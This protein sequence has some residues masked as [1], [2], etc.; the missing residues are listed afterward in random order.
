M[1]SG[2]WRIAQEILTASCSKKHLQSHV[3]R[4]HPTTLNG[5]GQNLKNGIK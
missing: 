3:G 2:E 4:V 5:E 1:Y